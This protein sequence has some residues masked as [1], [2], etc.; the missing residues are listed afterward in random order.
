M[1]GEGVV[2][3]GENL[4]RSAAGAFVHVVADLVHHIGVVAASPEHVVV[5]CASVE[6]IVA[7][8]AEQ[9]VVAGEAVDRGAVAAAGDDV[10]LAGSID[11]VLA[12]IEERRVDVGIGAADLIE[13]GDEAAVAEQRDHR[14]DLEVQAAR[15]ELRADLAAGRVETLAAGVTAG[16][17]VPDHDETAV[18][19]ADD[20]GR[21][22]RAGGR[23]IDDERHVECVAVI[24]EDAGDDAV[25]GAI[26]VLSLHTATNPPPASAAT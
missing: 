16:I 18:R 6:D 19:Q 11:Q 15:L 22:L 9:R 26:A 24:V 12:G 10:V 14:L 23:R 20:I 3:A 21:E 8:L 1:G 17:V 4:I 13:T 5:A 25:P 2:D 7:L